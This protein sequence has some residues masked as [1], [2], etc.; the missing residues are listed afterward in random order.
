MGGTR[1]GT[2]SRCVKI[3]TKL[4][5]VCALC[6]SVFSWFQSP[7][8]ASPANGA[9]SALPGGDR[10]FFYLNFTEADKIVSRL[11]KSEFIRWAAG[12]NLFVNTHVKE[13]ALL[14]FDEAEPLSKLHL[15]AAMRFDDE[16]RDV[17]KKIEKKTAHGED[18]ANL[19]APGLKKRFLRVT[20]PHPNYQDSF[21]YVESLGFYISAQDDLLIFGSTPEI[22]KKSLSA[23]SG[24]S[25][26]FTRKAKAEGRNNVLFQMGEEVT[27]QISR[28]LFGPFEEN[29]GD[30]SRP[31]RFSMEG[32]VGLFPG[33][34]DLDISSNALPLFFGKTYMDRM[35]AKSEGSFYA[36]GG[37]QVLAMVDTTPAMKYVLAQVNEICGNISGSDFLSLPVT[38]DL[39]EIDRVNAAVTNDPENP[40]DIRAYVY[41]SSRKEGVTRRVGEALAG[42]LEASG[43]WMAKGNELGIRA[44]KIEAGDGKRAFALDLPD[45]F[46]RFFP[47]NRLSVVI[48]DGGVLCAWM[49]LSLLSVPFEKRS[50]AYDGLMKKNDL[51]EKCFFDARAIRKAVG[52]L[53]ENGGLSPK[54]A[55]ILK[56]FFIPFMDIRETTV[57]VSSPERVRFGFRTGWFDL[58][59]RDTLRRL[60]K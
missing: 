24:H 49:P 4:M 5:L 22:L 35:F 27:E 10:T 20:E 2:V 48:E 6:A 41:L 12:E 32:N 52:A 60:M 43:N 54:A 37:G 58:E 55:G 15:Q 56:H 16:H 31:K 17:L 44:E 23:A 57:E 30:E 53:S 25:R 28:I 29:E 39:Q 7:A 9:L 34:W 46:T 19:I 50:K 11:G 18:V 26:R 1:F 21:Y 59:E 45:K 13:L 3:G 36:A 14:A 8:A 47:S 42:A 51:A 33:G 38:R 40:K